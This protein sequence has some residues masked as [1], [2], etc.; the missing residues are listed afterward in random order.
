MGTLT[1]SWLVLLVSQGLT[2]SPPVKTAETF[3]DLD[4][5]TRSLVK[6]AEEPVAHKQPE[7]DQFCVLLEQKIH[8]LINQERVNNK[9][10][11]LV[12]DDKLTQAARNHSQDMATRRY[13]NHKSPEGHDF[14]WRYQQVGF[15]GKITIGNKYYLGAENIFSVGT[16]GA[17][18]SPD[19]TAKEIVDGWMN[20]KGHRYNILTS[21]WLR[22]GIGVAI[23]PR[24]P[25]GWIWVYATENFC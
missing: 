10:K 3:D 9:L 25:N 18:G 15:T 14:L 22:E 19:A 13:F 20:S 5:L 2:A 23:A 16:T 11:P 17:S 4:L 1:K 21:Y 8:E 12:W 7:Q 24:Q 6:L